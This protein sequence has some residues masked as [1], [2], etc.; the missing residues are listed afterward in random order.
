MAAPLARVHQANANQAAALANFDSV[1][2][3]ALRETEQSLATYGSELQRHQA[4]TDAQD[5]A[6]RAYQLAQGQLDAGAVSPLDLLSSEN[7][8]VSADAAMAGSDATVIQDQIAVFK[9]LG[10]GWEPQ[11]PEVGQK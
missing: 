8:M 2:L 4:L 1:V 7:T 5:Q 9:A 6:H 3:A 11:N 10:G